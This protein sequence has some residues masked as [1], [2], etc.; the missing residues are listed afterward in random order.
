MATTVFVYLLIAIAALFIVSRATGKEN[1][2]DA[3]TKY[4]GCLACGLFLGAGAYHYFGDV[5]PEKSVVV[6]TDSIP[7]HQ[8]DN[9]YVLPD[10]NTDVSQEPVEC[11]TV[12]TETEENL[13]QTRCNVEI[14]DDS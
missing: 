1:R 10:N 11:D 5:Q 8:V 14:E 6:A 12:A 3:F 13:A 7:T 4:L 2:I 9:A